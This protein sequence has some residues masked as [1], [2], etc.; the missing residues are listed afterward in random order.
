MALTSR[1]PARLSSRPVC[2]RPPPM[3]MPSSASV[4]HA[5]SNLAPLSEILRITVKDPF[6]ATGSTK[7][8]GDRVPRFRLR[9]RRRKKESRSDYPLLRA[10]LSAV[11]PLARF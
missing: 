10:H 1:I 2:R 8:A 11:L 6:F 3:P 7:E 5:A 4:R 9:R